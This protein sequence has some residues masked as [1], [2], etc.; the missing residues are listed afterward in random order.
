MILWRGHRPGKCPP[1]LPAVPTPAWPELTTESRQLFF[2]CSR[3]IPTPVYL[4]PGVKRHQTSDTPQSTSAL[5]EVQYLL[6]Q[7]SSKVNVNPNATLHGKSAI[8][9]TFD[10]GRFSYWISP[11]TYQPL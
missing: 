1:A 3:W 10:G 9:L 8:Q 6:G 4:A 7:S 2:E 5:A 11:R